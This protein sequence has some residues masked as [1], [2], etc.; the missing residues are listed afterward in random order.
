MRVPM[1]YTNI[2]LKNK[3][4]FTLRPQNLCIQNLTCKMTKNFYSKRS[5]LSHFLT[6]P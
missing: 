5:D 1:I 3:I 6:L 2:D 4:E